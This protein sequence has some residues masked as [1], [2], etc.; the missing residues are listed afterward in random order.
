MKLPLDL[1]V[2]VLSS[3]PLPASPSLLPLSSRRLRPRGPG[4]PGR[5]LGR[6]QHGGH[7]QRA[8]L[9]RVVGAWATRQL[10]EVL[11]GEICALPVPAAAPRC[12]GCCCPGAGSRGTSAAAAAAAVVVVAT[13]AV[14]A[15]GSVPGS[16]TPT[17]AGPAA[18]AVSGP[19][20]CLRGLVVSF[21]GMT[22]VYRR[23]ISR[24]T[25][26]ACHEAQR[27]PASE[28]RGRTQA[29]RECE[30]SEEA[31]T[32]LVSGAVA[33][34][35]RVALG[36]R[37]SMC[38]R[39]GPGNEKPPNRGPGERRQPGAKSVPRDRAALHLGSIHCKRRILV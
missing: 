35:N 33:R 19:S 12:C 37:W 14:V 3:V 13:A 10:P 34:I 7:V 28:P 36:R 4:S 27:V 18:A 5:V 6:P 20:P 11:R 25:Q 26:Y 21:Y 22:V 16:S 15:A 9:A 39:G 1:S 29:S 23:R 2:S 32:A 17:V 24:I 30:V 8:D 38:L 31:G